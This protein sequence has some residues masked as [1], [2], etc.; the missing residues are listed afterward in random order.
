MIRS[1]ASPG[2]APPNQSANNA[3]AVFVQQA[4]VAKTLRQR[5]SL[6]ITDDL[7]ATVSGTT[8]DAAGFFTSGSTLYH[9]APY[10]LHALRQ[11]RPHLLGK[12]TTRQ[13]STAVGHAHH[14]AQ[15]RCVNN[16]QPV[17]WYPLRAMQNTINY[18]KSY[19][20]PIDTTHLHA[21]AQECLNALRHAQNGTV[22]GLYDVHI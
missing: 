17:G 19:A 8:L 1:H 11:T 6:P 4:Q 13:P 18:Y 5:A 16:A 3:I 21:R 7:H 14:A 12:D 2:Y 15:T 20:I 10:F 9:Q 22:L